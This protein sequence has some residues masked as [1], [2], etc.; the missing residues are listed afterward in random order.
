VIVGI[1]GMGI[2]SPERLNQMSDILG[3]AKVF[4]LTILH[5]SNTQSL[6]YEKQ[7]GQ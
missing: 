3:R 5:D 1:S 7:A 6:A 4:N 2:D